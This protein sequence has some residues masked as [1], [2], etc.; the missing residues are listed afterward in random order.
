MNIN[1]KLDPKENETREGE[2]KGAERKGKVEICLVEES[3]NQKGEE[4]ISSQGERRFEAEL[5]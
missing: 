4:G 3:G 5:D 1:V 2:R